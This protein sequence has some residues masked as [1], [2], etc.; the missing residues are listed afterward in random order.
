[1]TPPEEDEVQLSPEDVERIG[2]LLAG[3]VGTSHEA[4]EKVRI[5][6]HKYWSFPGG[7]E[8]AVAGWT[9]ITLGQKITAN[10]TNWKTGEKGRAW[11]FS[12]REDMQLTAPL[13]ASDGFLNFPSSLKQWGVLWSEADAP[14]T[15]GYP[16]AKTLKA[17]GRDLIILG[18]KDRT[19][20]I[21]ENAKIAKE[22]I[23]KTIAQRDGAAPLVVGGFSMGGLITRYT[24]ALMER[25]Q[26]DP[27]IEGPD[28]ET[29]TYFSYDSPHRGGWV[30]ISIQAFAHYLKGLI[31]SIPQL[32][33]TLNSPASRQM[34]SYHIAAL[35]ANPTPVPDPERAKFLSAL[36]DVGGFPKKVQ[37]R[38]AVANGPADRTVRVVPS[39]TFELESPTREAVLYGQDDKAG[40]RVAVLQKR[41]GTQADWTPVDVSTTGIPALDG[42]PGGTLATNQIAVDILKQVFTGATKLSTA[43][44]WVCFVPTVSAVDVADPA[45]ATAAIPS[46]PP[47]DC[48]FHAY[49]CASPSSDPSRLAHTLLTEELCTWITA[50]LA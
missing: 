8:T 34:A 40:H 21:L 27:D 46:S 1:M 18:Y 14:Y 41:P 6:P 10:E 49:K 12:A 33:N 36:A 11:V 37:K 22:C 48:I 28:H 20:S 44:P 25:E 15:A 3:A 38:I 47:P 17:K 42:A 29:S 2:A 43:F 32:S 45:S 7:T 5:P 23:L 13:I 4:G 16:W 50:N 26:E 35:P 39:V 19:A 9:E 24:L 30:P 31:P